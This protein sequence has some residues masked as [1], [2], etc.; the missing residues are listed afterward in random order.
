MPQALELV[1]NDNR[2]RRCATCYTCCSAFDAA[3]PNCGGAILD[4][5][6]YRV[7]FNGAVYDFKPMDGGG[8]VLSQGP[9]HVLILTEQDLDWLKMAG[10]SRGVDLTK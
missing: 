7:M 6:R 4:D 10:R 2:S 5:Y 3:C 8:V 9:A 1:P